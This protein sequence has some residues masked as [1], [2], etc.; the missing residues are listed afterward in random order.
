M[1]S[2]IREQALDKKCVYMHTTSECIYT[3]DWPRALG[4]VLSQRSLFMKHSR[5]TIA[6]FALAASISASAGSLDR[7]KSQVSSAP[8]APTRQ[9]I[10]RFVDA[11]TRQDATALS[12]TITK[13]F[14][15]TLYTPPRFAGTTVDA[16]G[17]ARPWQRPAHLRSSSKSAGELVAI[18]PT[19][20]ARTLFVTYRV[21]G[22]AGEHATLVVVRGHRVTGIKDFPGSSESA[23]SGNS[24]FGVAHN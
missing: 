15:A 3:L 8:S 23:R 10:Q 5:L 9:L 22:Q 7:T 24:D 1:K 14:T 11:Y 12:R 18:Y 17:L 20:E 21:L 13:D 2:C 4:L 19:P 6:G 16:G